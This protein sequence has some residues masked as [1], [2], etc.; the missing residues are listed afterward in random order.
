[1]LVGM[2]K[3]FSPPSGVCCALSALGAVGVGMVGSTSS[4][5]G[6]AG[7]LAGLG[8][9]GAQSLLGCISMGTCGDTQKVWFPVLSS[10][11][12]SCWG[13]PDRQWDVARPVTLVCR[14]SPI[15]PSTAG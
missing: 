8:A 4:R 1:M 10:C 13:R 11:P 6:R 2:A 12:C 5:A 9:L 3:E 7:S 14:V 15:Y